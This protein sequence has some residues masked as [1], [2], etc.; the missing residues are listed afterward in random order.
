MS[1]PARFRSTLH[2]TR[3]RYVNGCRCEDCT[4]ADRAYHRNR[5]RITN[6]AVPIDSLLSVCW[7]CATYLFVPRADV[8]AGRTESCGSPNCVDTAA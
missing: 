3:G 1:S 6:K 7:C 5:G 2:G 4:A 8:L